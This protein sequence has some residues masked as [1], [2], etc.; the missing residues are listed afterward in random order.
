M[1][2]CMLAV[3][4][5]GLALVCC[6]NTTENRKT[7]TYNTWTS[8][9]IADYDSRFWSVRLP[10]VNR[11]T[12]GDEDHPWIT[13][14]YDEVDRLVND[15]LANWDDGP[16]PDREEFRKRVISQARCDRPHY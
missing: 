5:Q 13:I 8:F 11:T 4:L 7:F 16:V 2:V 9:Q 10:P 14:H 1:R 12:C 3:A 15:R 6:M